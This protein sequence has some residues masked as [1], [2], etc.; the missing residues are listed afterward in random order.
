MPRQLG[1]ES[2]VSALYLII[3]SLGFRSVMP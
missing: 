1:S 3:M 2:S